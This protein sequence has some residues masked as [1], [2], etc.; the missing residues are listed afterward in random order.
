MNNMRY[1]TSGD[2]GGL[3]DYQERKAELSKRSTPLDWLNERVEWEVFREVLET[4]KNTIWN[5]K[6]RL[7][8]QGMQECFGKELR[9]AGLLASKGKIMAAS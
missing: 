3:F 7:G 9:E 2:Q 1:K 8:K 4:D 6:K 5:Y